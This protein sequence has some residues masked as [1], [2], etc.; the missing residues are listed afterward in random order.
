LNLTIF[1]ILTHKKLTDTAFIHYFLKF[2]LVLNDM[3]FS[4]ALSDFP[5][6]SCCTSYRFTTP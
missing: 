1:G 6:A 2:S 3:L 5:F 4:L